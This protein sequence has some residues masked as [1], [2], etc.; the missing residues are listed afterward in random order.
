M[1]P[2]VAVVVVLAGCGQ[3]EPPSALPSVTPVASTPTGTPSAA[4]VVVPPEARAATPEGASAFARFFF[5]T[6]NEAYRTRD[7]TALQAISHPDCKSCAVFVAQVKELRA[8][9]QTLENGDYDVVDAATS[10]VVEREAIVDMLLSRPVSRLRDRRGA[11]VEAEGEPL[12][13]RT[14]Q[15]LVSHDNGRWAARGLRL[16]GT[17]K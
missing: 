13:M 6:L 3:D 9:D 16:F 5:D 14:A 12:D 11:V 8:K 1:V 2:V 4:P 10:E 7:A 15:M 17:R